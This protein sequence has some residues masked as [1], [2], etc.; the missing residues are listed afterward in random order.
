[1]TLYSNFVK[2]GWVESHMQ[3]LQCVRSFEW[4]PTWHPSITQVW[5]YAASTGLK[6]EFEILISFNF[7]Y[8]M[9]SLIRC[10][11]TWNLSIFFREI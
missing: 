7:V 2:F 1:M 3:I 5:S 10:K 6:K 11:T 9:Y 8:N 4:D